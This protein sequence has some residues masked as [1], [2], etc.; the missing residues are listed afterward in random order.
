MAFC[1][2]PQNLSMFVKS[3]NVISDGESLSGWMKQ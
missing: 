3:V 2:Q 1:F